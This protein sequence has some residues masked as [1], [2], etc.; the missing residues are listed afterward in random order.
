MISQHDQPSCCVSARRNFRNLLAAFAL[1][2]SLSLA[3]RVNADGTPWEIE[4]NGTTDADGGQR[5]INVKLA[6]TGPECPPSVTLAVMIG[7]GKTFTEQAAFVAREIN[8]SP[9]TSPFLSAHR[10]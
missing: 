4:F 9:V 3:V 7:G 10:E 8:R 2:A 5:F 6:G 1:L